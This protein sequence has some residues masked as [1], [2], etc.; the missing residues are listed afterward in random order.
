MS[1]NLDKSLTVEAWAEITIKEWIKKVRELGIGATGQLVNSFYHHVNTN[2]NGIP[3]YVNFVF[4]YY[5]RM[6]DWGVGRS[7]TIENRD[8]LVNSGVS[9]RRQKPWFSSV[10]YTQLA[11][12]KHLMAEKYAQKAAV[13]VINDLQSCNNQTKSATSGK[14]SSSGTID[15]VT[16]GEKIT[17]KEF[18]EKRKKAGW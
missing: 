8:M 12:L 2:A 4:E 15:P 7:V 13:V 1:E 10:F 9:T 14:R 17:Y 5:G 6:V 18:L 11:V 3:E 16:G